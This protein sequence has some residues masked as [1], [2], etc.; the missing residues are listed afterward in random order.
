MKLTSG[1]IYEKEKAYYNNLAKQYIEE[2]LKNINDIAYI[3]FTMKTYFT[4][5]MIKK[6]DEN[7]YIGFDGYVS[8]IIKDDFEKLIYSGTTDNNKKIYNYD[9]LLCM[10]GFE[11]SLNPYFRKQ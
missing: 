7:N 9:E 8:D 4:R 2:N 5:A 6:V 1:E 11:F 10:F 3:P